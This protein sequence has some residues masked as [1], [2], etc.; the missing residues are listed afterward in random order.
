MLSILPKDADTKYT[1][2][3]TQ[4]IADCGYNCTNKIVYVYNQEIKVAKTVTNYSCG[5]KHKQTGTGAETKCYR[6]EYSCEKYG[7]DY[8][9]NCRD[10][11]PAV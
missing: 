1:F 10:Y 4:V 11:R 2:V 3:K 7:K 8:E 6:I 9:I 5:D